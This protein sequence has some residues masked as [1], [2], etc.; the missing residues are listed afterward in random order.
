MAGQKNKQTKN[1]ARK[2]MQKSKKNGLPIAEMVAMKSKSP[3]KSNIYKGRDF[4]ATVELPAVITAANQV[5]ANVPIAPGRFNGSR[6]SLLARAYEK[7]RFRSVKMIY[8]PSVPTTVGGQFVMYF[9]LDAKDVPAVD[10][11]T[12]TVIRNAMA[13]QGALLANVN[14][15]HTVS[16]PIKPGLTDFFTGVAD[17]P[18]QLYYQAV[19]W[20]V[21]T[22][23]LNGTGAPATGAVGSLFVEYEVMFEG[24]QM[25]GT[26]GDAVEGGLP[27]SLVAAFQAAGVG[28]I[29]ITLGTVG[30]PVLF[31]GVSVLGQTATVPDGV[32]GGSFGTVLANPQYFGVNS[33]QGAFTATRSI[34]LIVSGGVSIRVSYAT[35]PSLSVGQF[36]PFTA[37]QTGD[38]VVTNPVLLTL[39]DD[40]ERILISNLTP[41]PALLAEK[42]ADKKRI[43]DLE[44]RLV[45][46]E[47]H[48]RYFSGTVEYEVVEVH[49][50]N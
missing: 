17:G 34:I 31:N 7:Y 22:A 39:D 6:I 12:T 16:M 35:Q 5:R 23:G 27:T 28:T 40:T 4:I 18:E 3:T 46:L 50:E 32:Y 11:G 20:I 43:C 38:N 26:A 21:A 1:R 36:I 10:S 30:V 48:M 19:F 15:K 49:P 41:T 9:D 42:M 13:H 2:A 33:N 37:I 8:E 24:E 25:K 29:P 47:E 45:E 44:R 14:A